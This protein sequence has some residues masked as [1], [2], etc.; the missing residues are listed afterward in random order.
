MDFL[1]SRFDYEMLTKIIFFKSV[2]R[3]ITV[4]IDLHH[5]H[6]TGKIIGYTH[7][8]CNMKEKTKFNSLA[9]HITFLDLVWFF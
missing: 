1:Q 4:K 5:L 9:L 3:I 8:F 7:D 6:V 2:H